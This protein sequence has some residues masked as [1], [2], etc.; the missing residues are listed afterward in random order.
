[1][2]SKIW[3][4][5]AIGIMSCNPKSPH[6]NTTAET[7]YLSVE[8]LEKKG[9]EIFQESPGEA[10]IFF[11]QAAV[12]HEKNEHVKKAGI[13]N[14]NIANIFDEYLEKTDSALVY[15]EKAL[16]IWKRHYDTLQ[17]ANLYKYIGLLK[18]KSGKIDEAKSDIQ[19]AIMMYQK[20]GFG[21]GVAVSEFNLADV[22]FRDKNFTEAEALFVK[23]KDFWN[24]NGDLGRIFTNNI[25]GIKIY[26]M[27]EDK[28]KAEKLIEENK[29]IMNQ[30]KDGGFAATR[31]SFVSENKKLLKALTT[32]AD[33]LLEYRKNHGIRFKVNIASKMPKVIYCKK[34]KSMI[35]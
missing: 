16:E 27:V 6:G 31:Y 25:L 8:E 4:I 9:F 3:T 35:F 30:T 5:L 33:K 11:K 13:T 18:G 17:M 32:N 24:G 26:N 20:V 2:K 29:A 15:S 28:A 14:L 1:M 22:Y 23:S 10:I 7:D 21:Q 12:I 34:L 19:Q